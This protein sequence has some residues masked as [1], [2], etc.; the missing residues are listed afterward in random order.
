MEE[1]QITSTSLQEYIQLLETNQ[2]FSYTRWGDGEWGCVFGAEG[3]NVDHHEYFP[4]MA[5]GLRNA[6]KADKGYRKATWPYTAPM[7]RNIKPQVE[8]YLSSHNLSKKWYDARVWE[9]AA[10][11]G[12]ISSLISQLEEMNL[13]FVT[14]PDKQKL[15][16]HRVGFIEIPSV[17]CFLARDQIKQAMLEVVERFDNPVFAFSASM[18]TNVIIDQ[19]YDQIGNDCWM[20]DFGSIW[21]PYIGKRTRSY[22]ERYPEVTEVDNG[23]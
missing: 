19:I 3:Y 12:E 13:I 23:Q 20:I 17:N 8:E 4:E 6:L 10:M 21:E 7:L 16:I 2:K 5:E 14:E 15:P 18:A 11:S 9:D 1:I 22:H